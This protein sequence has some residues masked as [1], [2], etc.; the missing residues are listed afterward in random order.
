MKNKY[1]VFKKA[2]FSFILVGCLATNVFAFDPSAIE[3]SMVKKFYAIQREHLFWLSSDKGVERATEW[4]TYIL[5]ADYSGS[6]LSKNQNQQI[7]GSLRTLANMDSTVKEKTDQQITALVLDFLKELQQGNINF[8]YDEVSVSRVP[9]YINQM[10]ESKQ[11][12]S[13][14]KLVSRFECKDPDYQILKKYLE[15]SITANDSLKYKKVVLAMNYRKYLSVNQPSECIVVNIPAADAKYYCNDQVML[16]MRAVVGQKTKPTPT[17]A[18]YITNIVTFP[19]WNV[20][21]SIGIKELL[22]KI[23]KNETYLQQNNYE[24]VDSKGNLVQDSD[25]KWAAYNETN[26][27]YFFRQSTGP[28]NSL[29]VVKFDLQDPFSIFLHGTSQPGTFAKESRFLSHGCVRLEKP[30][31]LAN[32]LLRGSLDIKA[33]KGGKKN[34]E[35][36]TIMLQK[37][38]TTFII[39]MPVM[40]DG[41]RVIFLKDPYGL[42]K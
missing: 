7:L 33:L 6:V 19:L 9:V 31:E 8:D 14:S 15:D 42:I 4:L 40:V 3:E 27:P 22:P 24:V 35:S 11:W 18:S 13:V 32:A 25:L 20:P 17:I 23:Q 28:G 36:N 38:I 21:Q 41:K 30:F 16:K 34:T 26:F 10:M 29:G 12:E 2:L 37:K 1:I 5:S 39:Y